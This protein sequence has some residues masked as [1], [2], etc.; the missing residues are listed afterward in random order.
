[1]TG[2]PTTSR[3]QVSVVL[4]VAGSLL[5]I[6]MLVLIG[7]SGRPAAFRATVNVPEAPPASVSASRSHRQPRC[8]LAERHIQRDC[9]ERRGI[10]DGEVSVLL[11]PTCSVSA[12]EVG[13]RLM[14]GAPIAV[15][16]RTAAIT[17]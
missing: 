12:R 5:A 4:G 11:S 1:M 8:A 2:P 3:L 9:R 6:V 7:P 13:F 17:R 10:G 16:L 15:P 14:A